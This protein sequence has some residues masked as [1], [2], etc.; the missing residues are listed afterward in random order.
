MTTQTVS[1]PPTHIR[2]QNWFYG[3]LEAWM[4]P[5]AA[6]FEPY[7]ETWRF[8]NAA[9]VMTVA[10][11]I[12]SLVISYGLYKE[13]VYAAVL[14]LLFL[15]GV[16]MLLDGVDGTWARI[17]ATTSKTGRILDGL[18][19]RLTFAAMLVALGLHIN[20]L[21]AWPSSSAKG[22]IAGSAIL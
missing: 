16:C 17:T 20:R 3:L 14:G 5:Y 4:E 19:D 6:H 2:V 9:N 11:L 7:R 1:A 21:E 8:Q 22:V 18:A 10:R 15:Q 13:D 12:A